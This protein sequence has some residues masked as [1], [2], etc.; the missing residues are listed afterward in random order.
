MLKDEYWGQKKL[1]S[2][3]AKLKAFKN[4]TY[5]EGGE[6]F[7]TFV[8]SDGILHDCGSFVA[9]YLYTDNPC[10]FMLKDSATNENN[11]ALLGKECLKHY[12]QAFNES[13]IIDF[14]ENVVIKGNDTKKAQRIKFAKEVL[15]V[16]FPNVADKILDNIKSIV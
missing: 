2:Y 9:E 6:Y 13:D 14:I 7:E 8:N 5:Q 10:C 11:F 12:Y 3:L 1:D 4:V 16:N 15:R